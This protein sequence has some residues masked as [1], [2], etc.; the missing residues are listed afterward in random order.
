MAIHWVQVGN[1]LLGI[2]SFH[3]H[4][5]PIYHLLVATGIHAL[6]LPLPL[7]VSSS[8]FITAL[9][10]QTDSPSACPSGKLLMALPEQ[11]FLDPSAA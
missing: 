3:L 8:C 2:I 1:V 9:L 4:A 6:P 10:K 7:P 11:S 5:Y